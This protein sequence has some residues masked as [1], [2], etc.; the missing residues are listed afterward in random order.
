MELPSTPPWL[1]SPAEGDGDSPRSALERH[2]LREARDFVRRALLGC[3]RSEEPAAAKAEDAEVTLWRHLSRALRHCGGGRGL[4]LGYRLIS[5]SE[6]QSQQRQPCFSH[7]MWSSDEFRKWA[8]DSK[9]LFPGEEVLQRAHLILVGYLTDEGKDGVTN[10]SLYVRDDTGVLPCEVLTFKLEWLE[11]LLLFPSWTYIPQKGPNGAGYLEILADPVQ[12]MPGPEKKID[13]PPVLDS[14]QAAELL[15]ARAQCK[16]VAEL[17]VAGELS[18]LSRVLCI[19]HKVF[20]FLFLKSFRSDTC[21]PVLVQPPHLVWHHVLQLEQGYVVTALKVSSLKAS[22]LRVFVTNSSSHLLP[23]HTER[24]AEEFMD[25]TSEGSSILAASPVACLPLSSS[26]ELG[27]EVKTLVPVKKSK[28]ISYA[29]T[30][31]QV[32]NAQASLYELDKKFT[33]CLAYQQQ[34]N[35][36]RGLR[37]GACVELRDIHLLQK[38]LAAFPFVLG[39]C[40]RTSLV[41]RSFSKLSTLHQPVASGGNLYLQ[42]LLRYNLTVPLYLCLV[43]LLETLELR[44]SGFIRRQQLLLC[45]SHGAAG[46]AEK[47]IVPVLDSLMPSR[48]QARDLHREILAERHHCPLEQ[49]RTLEP[50]CQIPSFSLLFPMVEERCLEGFSPLRLMSCAPE[51]QHVGAQELNRKLAWSHRTLSAESFKPRLVLLGMLRASSGGGFLQLRDSTKAL[52]CTV[53]HRDGRPFADTSLIGCLLQIEAFQLVMEQFLQSDF[54]SWQ[55]LESP[56]YVKEKKTRLYAQFCVEDVKVLHS[57]EKR[58]PGDPIVPKETSSVAKDNESSGAE[59]RSPDGNL[60]NPE[61]AKRAANALEP[62]EGVAGEAGATSRLFLVTQKEGLMRRNYLQASEGEGEGDQVQQLCFQATALWMS[63][64]EQC[65]GEA[66][67]QKGLSAT[68]IGEP[69]G[70]RTDVLLL[71][72][73]KAIRWFPVLHPGGLYQLIIPQCSGLDI[74]DKSCLPVGPGNLSNMKNCSLFFP[75]PE[76]A[77]LHHVSWMSEMTPE[78]SEVGQKLFSIEEILGPS[79]T[80]S[81]VSFSGVISERALCESRTGKKPVA[82]CSDKLQQKGNFL[83]W[84]YTVKL[85]VLPACGLSAGLDVYVEAAFLPCLWGALPGAKILFH[86]LQ[87]KVSRFRNVYCTYVASSCVSVLSSPPLPSPSRPIDGTSNLPA[88]YLAQMQPQSPSLCQLRV[89]CH[90]TCV[91]SLS[92]SWTCSLCDSIIKEG[93]C[94]QHNP[95]CSSSTGVIKAN[96]RILVEDGTGEAVVSCRNQQVC[97]VLNLNPKEWDVVQAHVRRKGLVS[98]RH[99][100]SSGGPGCTEDPEGLLTRYLRSLCR[101]PAVLRSLVLEARLDR[102]PPEA[103]SGQMR[104]FVSNEVAFL[105]QMRSRLNLICLSI[106]EAT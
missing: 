3:G 19:H 17:N 81:L 2:W 41:I 13:T 37:P 25:S 15:N 34:L 82:S 66:E 31:T 92:L 42:L 57:P 55:E 50:P 33:L 97:G 69:G 53:F 91:L 104:R 102:R 85:S 70:A 80:G 49:Y 20:F 18:R 106:R 43:S 26:V 46:A 76:T 8:C 86:N 32:L 59:P 28:V 83:P 94:G 103:G 27:E 105:T 51:V 89:T 45:S 23:Y 39:A 84:D 14:G 96:A 73:G 72:L 77:Y 98:L 88:M 40:L 64:P 11:T 24:V 63:K 93:R 38:P 16:K 12:V 79:F 48:K 30:I 4:P 9:S 6:L 60:A 58:G 10:G 87:R 56:E 54:P 74:F 78:A 29:G 35:S 95:P 5:I 71:F 75:V 1:P 65:R 44:F 100:E 90:V 22:G 36:G 68:A 7:W 47:F 99:N 52:P 67:G 62:P 21:V 101:S 61:R